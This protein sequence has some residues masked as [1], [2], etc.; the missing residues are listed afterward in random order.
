MVAELI[1]IPTGVELVGRH[2]KHCLVVYALRFVKSYPYMT[3]LVRAR[4]G[5]MR[6]GHHRQSHDVMPTRRISS[7]M[8]E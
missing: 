6:G 4:V 8:G 5:V 1:I 2:I 3:S 7:N